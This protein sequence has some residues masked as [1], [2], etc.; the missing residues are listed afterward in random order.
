MDGLEYGVGFVA[1]EFA[2]FFDGIFQFFAGV[3]GYLQG[4]GG[5]FSEMNPEA[6]VDGRVFLL[7]V[8]ESGDTFGGAEAKRAKFDEICAV[9]N[10]AEFVTPFVVLSRYFYDADFG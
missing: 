7:C 10:A 1:G 6:T 4:V 3:G 9:G 2:K 8:F 5:A